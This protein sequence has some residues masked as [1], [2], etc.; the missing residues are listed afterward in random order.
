MSEKFDIRLRRKQ[1]TEGRIERYKNYDSLLER[2]RRSSRKKT[3][4]RVLVVFVFLL[5]AA[6]AASFWISSRNAERL[7]KEFDGSGPEPFVEEVLP[8]I[9]EA[10]YE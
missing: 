8:E 4:L 7:N 3:A 6:L 1:F 10:D 2:H 9:D 5:L